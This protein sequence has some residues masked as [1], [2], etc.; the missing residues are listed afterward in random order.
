MEIIGSPSATSVRGHSWITG[1]GASSQPASCKPERSSRK[2]LKGLNNEDLLACAIA[3]RPPSTPAPI[4]AWPDPFGR[5][6]ISSLE[7]TVS[8]NWLTSLP[9]H[10][11]L[12]RAN[13][14]CCSQYTIKRYHDSWTPPCFAGT[15]TSVSPSYQH[16]RCSVGKSR[17]FSEAE[18]EK[19]GASWH[20]LISFI[21]STHTLCHYPNFH[22]MSFHLKS[23][24]RNLYIQGDISFLSLVMIILYHFC[25]HLF[26]VIAGFNSLRP[27]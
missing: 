6:T 17:A 13:I 3:R 14:H 21:F 22:L 1:I 15:R 20:S 23:F 26:L 27:I 18:D 5:V 4:K 10:W 12:L 9:R 8:A 25:S 24:C 11:N 16:G 19:G 7:H 2:A